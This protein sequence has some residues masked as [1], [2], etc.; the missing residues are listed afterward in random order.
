MVICHLDNI[1]YGHIC[2]QK[3]TYQELI[4]HRCVTDSEV[5]TNITGVPQHICTYE[6]M[7]RI[8]CSIVNYNIEQNTC[9]LSNDACSVLERDQAF[10]VNYLGNVQRSECLQWIPTSAL[11]SIG[12]VSNPYCHT[13]SVVCDIGR[14]VASPNVLPGTYFGDGNRVW[15][16]FDGNAF[17]SETGEILAVQAGCQVTWMPFSAGDTVPEGG[18]EGG[19]LA[20]NGAILYVMRAPANQFIVFGYYDP[21]AT[22]G[23]IPYTA[24]KTVT[25]MELLVLL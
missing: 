9:H 21:V 12:V 16:M 1:I 6:C 25:E 7:I 15:S 8:D 13:I 10:Q 22:I 3:H 17:Y 18:V 2:Q 20:S 4:G 11:G 19:F 23:Y 24:I 5:Y 14:I